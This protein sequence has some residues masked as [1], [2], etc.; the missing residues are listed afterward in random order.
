MKHDQIGDIAE[1]IRKMV[2]DAE[3]RGYARGMADAK[4]QFIAQ[5]HTIGGGVTTDTLISS[6]DVDEEIVDD[7]AERVRAPKGV[8]R[9][10]VRHALN[11]SPGLRPQEILQHARNDAERMVKPA[12]VRSEL[13]IGKR[14][15]AYRLQDGKWFL[16]ENVAEDQSVEGQ[17]SATKDE[18][19]GGDPHAAPLNMFD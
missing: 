9:Q 17:S 14:R 2:A 15:G 1:T 6:A 3:A 16:S 12:S 13:N 8:V 7:G 18:Q 19:N 10:L 4:Q 5:I 11:V